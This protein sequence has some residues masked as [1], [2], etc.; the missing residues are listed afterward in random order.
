MRMLS[1]SAA[2]TAV[3]CVLALLA[4]G[5]LIARAQTAP[6]SVRLALLP[7]WSVNQH[8]GGAGWGSRGPLT[9]DFR[10]A[11]AGGVV[12]RP[13]FWWQ[14]GLIQRSSLVRKPIRVLPP[15]E[16]APLG[17][18]GQFDLVSVRPPAGPAAWTDVEIASRGQGGD[19][20]LEVGGELNTITQVLETVL[21]M[22][23]DGAIQEVPLARRA[24]VSG[25]GIPVVTVQFG[26]PPAVPP[27][28]FGG[29][30][31]LDFLVARSPVESLTN[32]DTT[33]L[34]PA[35]RA[36][37]N[38]GDWREADRVFIRVPAA[39]LQAGVP[40]VVLV[41]KDRTLK[42]DPDGGEF[43]QRRSRL[44]LPRPR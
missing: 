16:A 38:V 2:P 17:G 8:R 33:T 37:A 34:G 9:P 6:L 27:T 24:L 1:R 13:V 14:R 25:P 36:T 4:I 20:V 40:G 15:A 12:D 19:L 7:Q 5:P 42:P 29:A 32:G 43:E 3:L 21:L 35:D 44:E 39:G 26:V 22:P 41:W 30:G 28:A 18:R 11:L 31:G 10:T 23:A